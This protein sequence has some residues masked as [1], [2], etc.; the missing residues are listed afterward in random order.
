MNVMTISNETVLISNN[1]TN[2]LDT[3]L[4][5]LTRII[6][7][8]FISKQVVDGDCKSDSANN[9]HIQDK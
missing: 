7:R 8:D 3:G 6:A 9:G 2:E 4:R 1:N 5:I